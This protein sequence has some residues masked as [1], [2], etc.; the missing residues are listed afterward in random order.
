LIVA[1]LWLM[2]RLAALSF[3]YARGRMRRSD[4]TGTRSLLLLGERVADVLI[5]LLAVLLILNIVGFDT[6]TALAGLGIVGVALAVGA[7][8]TVENFLG[9]VFLL[10]DKALSVGDLCSISNRLGFVEDVTLRS[11]R[12]RTLEQTLLSIPAGVLSQDSVE[13][14]S[15]RG[16]ILAQTILRLSYGTSTEQLRSILEDIRR[17]LSEHPKIET[18]SSRVR[19][20][21]FGERAIELEIFAYVLTS[22]FAEFLAVREELLLQIAEVVEASGASFARR[23]LL[24]TVQ[25]SAAA[26]EARPAIAKGSFHG[27]PDARGNSSK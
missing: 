11:I 22:V 10:S 25:E 1:L 12:L 7:Q 13:N 14:F 26:E 5:F 23:E 16:K 2:R 8:K 3:A 6:G 27:S 20:T 4:Q 15:T 18:E 9:G 17:L 19:L 21:D 24:A